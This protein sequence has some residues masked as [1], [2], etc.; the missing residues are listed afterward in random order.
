MATIDRFFFLANQGIKHTPIEKELGLS[1]GYLGKMRDR[2]ASI[3]QVL[4]YDCVGRVFIRSGTV[5]SWSVWVETQQLLIS[6]VNI[7]TLNGNSILGSGNMEVGDN[8][9]VVYLN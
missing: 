8:S 6:G 9:G 5:N 1:N 3:I 7:K 2:K 4:T